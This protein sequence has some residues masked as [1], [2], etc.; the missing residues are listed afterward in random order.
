LY[1]EQTIEQ[2]QE[3]EAD[4][5]EPARGRFRGEGG[6]GDSGTDVPSG[7][8]P[9]ILS[10]PDE[11]PKQD[12]QQGQDH[13]HEELVVE[14]R[15]E[16]R[17]DRRIVGLEGLPHSWHFATNLSGLL[18]SRMGDNGDRARTTRSRRF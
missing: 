8:R 7:N 17:G 2:P 15:S 4:P 16:C 11:I 14:S 3:S 12:D 1:L 13:E 9:S 18:V 5:K 6:S 10:A